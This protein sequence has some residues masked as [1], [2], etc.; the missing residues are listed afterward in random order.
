[1]EQFFCLLVVD[2]WYQMVFSQLPPLADSAILLSG[3]GAGG[4]GYRLDRGSQ[5]AEETGNE[6]EAET[7]PGAEHGPAIAVADVIRQAVQVPWVTRKLEVDAGNAGTEGDDAEGSSHEEEKAGHILHEASVP[8]AAEHADDPTEQDDGHRHAHE[9]CRHS[10][11]VEGVPLVLPYCLG[12][13]VGEVFGYCSRG[14]VILD[15]GAPCNGTFPDEIF[16]FLI[17][18]QPMAFPPEPHVG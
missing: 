8:A 6:G 12:D 11:Q 13:V 16:D 2:L 10:P 9:T 5:G 15:V 14:V 18:A 1:M 17:E 7:T 4:S 3:L